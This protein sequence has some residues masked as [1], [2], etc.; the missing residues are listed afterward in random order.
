MVVGLA[1]IKKLSLR[2]RKNMSAT[3]NG[4]VVRQ[5]S[6]NVR[7]SILVACGAVAGSS[8]LSFVASDGF[9]QT[10][11]NWNSTASGNWSVGSN[12][13]GGTE[14]VVDPNGNANLEFSSV[15]PYTSKD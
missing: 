8:L 9:A 1:Q 13:A 14:P 4:F 15:G 2:R 5:R 11:Y 3:V 7:K 6:R 12:W 10:S